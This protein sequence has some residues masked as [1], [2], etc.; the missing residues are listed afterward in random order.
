M[1]GEIGVFE[2]LQTL[3]VVVAAITV[4]L[5]SILFN[6]SSLSA[7]ERDQDLYDEAEHIIDDIESWER[8]EAVNSYGNRYPEFLIRQPEL[9]T[10]IKEGGF[11]D[12][13]RS[14]LNY[15]VTFDDLVV[16]DDDQ[17]GNAGVYSKYEFG[18]PVPED[19]ETVVT[20]V[21]YVLVMEK[22]LGPQDF[23]VSQRHACLLTVVVWR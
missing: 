15:N 6:W 3:V 2:D 16:S 9:V 20:Q 10:L 21:H 11:E 12:K 1:S 19:S 13:I 8:L 23:D 14:D 4:L 5:V 18:D 7:L 17:D 22:R